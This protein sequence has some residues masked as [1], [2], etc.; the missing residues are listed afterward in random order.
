M[1]VITR[2]T[3]EKILLPDLGIE[4]MVA[5]ILPTG[6]VRVGIRAPSGVKILREELMEVRSDERGVTSGGSAVSGGSP[7]VHGAVA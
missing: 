4:I 3:G 6:A 1:L 5:R 7:D 2:K